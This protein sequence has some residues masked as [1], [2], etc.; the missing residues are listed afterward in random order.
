M[1]GHGRQGLTSLMAVWEPQTKRWY[2]TAYL[3]DAMQEYGRVRFFND[4]TEVTLVND[5][6]FLSAIYTHGYVALV[7]ARLLGGI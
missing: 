5:A 4:L 3:A 2:A 1:T 7:R 6:T